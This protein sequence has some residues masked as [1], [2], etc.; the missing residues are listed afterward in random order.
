MGRTIG[1]SSSPNTVERT[2]SP[3]A[4]H[5]RRF[6]LFTS[7]P[8]SSSPSSSS[9]RFAPLAYDHHAHGQALSELLCCKVSSSSCFSWSTQL[10]CSVLQYAQE[11]RLPIYARALHSCSAYRQ[12]HE[13]MLQCQG[14][15]LAMMYMWNSLWEEGL[16]LSILIFSCPA[17]DCCLLS[18]LHI[19]NL[20]I[21]LIIHLCPQEHTSHSHPQLDRRPTLKDTRTSPVLVTWD[22]CKLLKYTLSLAGGS[23]MISYISSDVMQAKDCP[24]PA[25]GSQGARTMFLRSTGTSRP[26]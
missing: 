15:P 20:L 7:S 9:P 26:R 16:D 11:D 22:K 23:T 19:G 17:R 13:H 14:K 21:I 8:S 24:Q 5:L 18:S 10:Q 2:S 4:L 3:A 12:L 6:H 25:Q 1:S